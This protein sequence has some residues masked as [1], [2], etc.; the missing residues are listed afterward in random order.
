V[1][2]DTIVFTADWIP[3]HELAV[4]AGM[5]LDSGTRG[6]RVDTA[7]R[8][9]RA[10]VFAAGNLLQGAEP[11]DVAALSGRHAA[12][13]AARWLSGGGTWP[14]DPAR[15]IPIACRPPLHWISPNAIGAAPDPPPR[16]RFALRS[17]AFHRAPVIE[18]RQNGRMLWQGRLP[19]LGPGRSTGLPAGW[20]AA[21][22]PLG[23]AVEVGLAG[24]AQTRSR[25]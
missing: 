3:D 24:A 10:G 11:A 8:T 4:M 5:E 25:G 13:S 2:C 7:L 14:A 21:V 1:A 19:R 12:A 9:M 23:G 22:D 20:I 17:R 6:P 18:I 16:G 15:S